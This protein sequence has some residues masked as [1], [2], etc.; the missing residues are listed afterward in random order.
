MD[1]SQTQ[2]GF[3]FPALRAGEAGRAFFVAGLV[4]YAIAGAPTPDSYGW[5]E[6]LIAG[7]LLCAVRPP[8]MG[9][10]G[11][12]LWA[13]LYGLCGPTLVALIHGAA[14]PDMLRD[15]VP[16]LFLFLILVYRE[17]VSALGER[18][19]WLV[20]LIG[21][22]FS[23]RALVPYGHVWF[24]GGD[25]FSG[26]PQDLLYLSNSPEVLFSAIWLMG[27]GMDQLFLR[28][29]VLRG[30]GEM[31]LAAL[32]VLAMALM[33]QRAGLAAVACAA[34]FFMVRLFYRSPRRFLWAALFLGVG[35]AFLWPVLS[36]LLDAALW[37]T[38]VVGLNSRGQEWQAVL[39][40][41]T[42]GWAESLFGY[43]WGARFEN[44]AV[45]GLSVMFTHS[46][47][48]SL[49]FKTGLAGIVLSGGA[50]AIGLARGLRE[51]LKN[52]SLGPAV[53]FPLLI[54]GAIYA[55]YKSL[56]FGLI[57]LICLEKEYQKLETDSSSVA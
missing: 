32:P 40:L 8:D 21:V 18:F 36:F 34:L 51:V 52:P 33:M 30:A 5:V 37:K 13:V 15:L 31:V 10:H 45:G 14:F 1:I 47:L 2:K 4:L 3:L 27:H 6:L 12:M 20:A 42:S 28:G 48:S 29:R 17:H 53:L 23:V 24:A 56:G 25:P 54:S 44:P 46:F 57:L 16:F 9:R 22:L 11:V 39:S 49:W 19:Y 41:V 50:V 43:G 7:F 38:R 55:S 35:G 26:A